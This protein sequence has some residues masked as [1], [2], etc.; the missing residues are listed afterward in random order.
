MLGAQPPEAAIVHFCAASLIADQGQHAEA[1]GHYNKMLAIH[2]GVMS[3]R[4]PDTA[5]T[6]NKAIIFRKQGRQ[7]DWI[8]TGITQI[9]VL[10][11]RHPDT[12]I[13][14]NSMVNIAEGL[15]HYV[16]TLSIR[17]EVRGAS[18]TRTRLASGAA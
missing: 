9:G 18:D 3:E 16:N 13:I 15:A 11:E 5:A 2:R 4:H 12:A 14:D 10:D 17:D 8:T 7:A 6:H 1:L